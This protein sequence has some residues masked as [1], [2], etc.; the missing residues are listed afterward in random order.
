MSGFLITG[1]VLGVI[2]VA[3]FITWIATS[4]PTLEDSMAVPR[5]VPV[6]KGIAH[7]RTEEDSGA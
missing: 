1:I 3:S 4:T 2:F 5:D 6:H 7:E